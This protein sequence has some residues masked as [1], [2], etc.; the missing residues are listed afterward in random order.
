MTDYNINDYIS[1]RLQRAKET[2]AEVQT[3]IEHEY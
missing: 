1:Y 3:L 2:L